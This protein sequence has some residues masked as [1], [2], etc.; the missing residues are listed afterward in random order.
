MDVTAPQEVAELDDVEPDDELETQPR[1]SSVNDVESD[2]IPSELNESESDE[3]VPSGVGPE[4]NVG[5]C[6]FDALLESLCEEAF[7]PV[8]TPIHTPVPEE[9]LQL[10]PT[11]IPSLEEPAPVVDLV[12]IP[13]QAEKKNSPRKRLVSLVS[14][15]NEDDAVAPKKY[16]DLKSCTEAE[17][18]LPRIPL[19]QLQ[20]RSSHRDEHEQPATQPRD[21]YRRDDNRSRNRHSTSRH[22]SSGHRHP[23]DRLSEEQRRWLD[24]MPSAWRRRRGRCC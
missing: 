20:E 1:G 11:P 12:P 19:K 4:L 6:T 18:E 16:R 10:H 13:V 21:Q 5:D 9:E 17:R 14:V 3:N 15:V 7:F 8:L 2:K 24:R 23:F 22:H